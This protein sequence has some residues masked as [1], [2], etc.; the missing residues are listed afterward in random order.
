M[1]DGLQTHYRC[2]NTKGIRDN[3]FEKKI[4][5]TTNMLQGGGILGESPCIIA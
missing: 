4:I 2:Y 3:N 1:S 5:F